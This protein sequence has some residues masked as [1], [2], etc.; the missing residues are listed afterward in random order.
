MKT[1]IGVAVVATAL[2]VGGAVATDYAVAAPSK[3]SARTA[4]SQ[5]G[6]LAEGD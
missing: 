3:A 2:T 4:D 6:R 1:W 5:I